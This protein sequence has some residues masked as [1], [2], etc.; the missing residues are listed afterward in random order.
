MRVQLQRSRS[1][2]SS[3]WSGG[4]SHTRTLSLPERTQTVRYTRFCVLSVLP[5]RPCMYASK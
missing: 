5:L 3:V 1:C 2:R 4:F